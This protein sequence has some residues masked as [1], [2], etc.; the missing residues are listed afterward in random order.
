MVTY[1]LSGLGLTLIVV[2]LS[3]WLIPV[4]PTGRVLG[5]IQCAGFAGGIVI[6]LLGARL[7]H[8]FTLHPTPKIEGNLMAAA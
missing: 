4:Y 2:L 3:I 5:L 1:A 7:W 8:Y 6:S